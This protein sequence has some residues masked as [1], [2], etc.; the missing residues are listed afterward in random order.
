MINKSKGKFISIISDDDIMSYR[1]FNEIK[2]LQT[3]KINS[4]IAFSDYDLKKLN[5]NI[6]KDFFSKDDLI[7]LF[8][9][10]NSY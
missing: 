3:N 1:I 9:F 10:K 5:K 7:K 4:L 6:E 8:F 2:N